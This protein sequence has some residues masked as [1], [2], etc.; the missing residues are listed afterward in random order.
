ME[1]ASNARLAASAA[2]HNARMASREA[3]FQRSQAQ[4]HSTAS[5]ISDISIQGYWKRSEINDRRCRKEVDMI[6]ERNTMINPYT[7][8]TIHVPS[9]YN[10]YYINPQ[11]NVIGS[12]NANFKPNINRQ[13]NGI[14][15]KKLPQRY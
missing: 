6:R 12:N 13:Y 8:P 4:Y 3:A 15:W 11:G 5:G 10:Q 1:Q 14:E 7:N 9:G 2:A